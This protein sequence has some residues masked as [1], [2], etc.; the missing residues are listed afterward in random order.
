MLSLSE[1]IRSIR[2]R[3][4]ATQTAFAEL[5]KIR[6]NT[7]SQYER[8]KN[9][10][11]PGVLQLL[12]L[13]NI[14]P[15]EEERAP[16]IGVLRDE[17]AIF[18]PRVMTWLAGS[19][20]ISAHAIRR[21]VCENGGLPGLQGDVLTTLYYF[22]GLAMAS[23]ERIFQGVCVTTRVSLPDFTAA[24]EHLATAGYIEIIRASKARAD[25]ASQGFAKS[26]WLN[27]LPSASDPVAFVK[28]LPA[29]LEF[30]QRIAA[31][32]PGVPF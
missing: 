10:L 8:R 6:Q 30:I 3:S 5:L 11:R 12:S 19:G 9:P 24:L 17:Y 32:N 1:A 20:I 15:T 26:D 13:F 14:A 29:G 25:F 21:L 28:L 7:V 22:Y 18:E 16:I 27:L 31:E 2:K 23:P 4:G